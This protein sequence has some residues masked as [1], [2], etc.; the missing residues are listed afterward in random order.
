[1][2]IGLSA[3]LVCAVLHCCLIRQHAAFL[4][5]NGHGVVSKSLGSRTFLE[6]YRR[7]RHRRSALIQT[8]TAEAA[9]QAVQP[10]SRVIV[11]SGPTGLAAAIMLASLG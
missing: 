11:G 8:L 1:M 5:P 7:V 2:G 10:E 4:F 3:T 6:T 9:V